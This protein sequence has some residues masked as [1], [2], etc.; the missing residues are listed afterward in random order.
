[1]IRSGYIFFLILLYGEFASHAANRDSL[2]NAWQNKELHDTLRRDAI[3]D[4]GWSYVN[5]NPDS[6][7]YY[8]KLEYNFCVRKKF[9]VGQSDAMNTTGV[10]YLM[11]AEYDSALVYLER[12]AQLLE[13][14]G[15]KGKA[16]I[17]K[18][19]I[20]SIYG[21]QDKLM[22]ALD[23]FYQAAEIFE[24]IEDSVLLVKAFFNIGVV[25]KKM[26]ETDVAL[27]HYFRALETCKKYNIPDME[28][29][30]YANIANTYKELGKID[31]SGYYIQKALAIQVT[32]G[33]IEG[34]GRSHNI[35]ADNFLL[36]GL[37]DSAKVHAYTA[38]SI[39]Q[40]ID[41]IQGI[42]STSNLLGRIHFELARYDS[43]L[44][45][46]NE[47]LR[48][49]IQ[50]SS[51][52]EQSSA[53]EGLARV[54]EK[55]GSY[56]D[57]LK[58]YKLFIACSDS[59]NSDENFKALAQQEMQ[60]E[61]NKKALH[62]S[63]NRRNELTAVQL[64]GEKQQAVA[65]EAGRRNLVI[66]SGVL[67]ALIL[68]GVIAVILYRSNKRRK[69][70]HEIISHQKSEV[71]LQKH[72]LEEKNDEITDSI[73]YAKRIQSAILPPVKLV[74]S[75]LP[76]SFVLYQ[77]KDIVAGDFYWCHQ[78]GDTLLLGVSDCTGHGVPGALVSVVCNNALT[79]SVSEYK[80]TVPNLVLDK[81]RELV[82]ETFERSE[83]QVRDGMDMALIAISKNAAGVYTKL[84]F[85]GANNGLYIIRN[86][87]LTE[88]KPDK[89]P[90]GKF[91][92]ARPFTLQTETLEPGDLVFLFSDGFADQFGGPKAK[93]LKY[94][95]LKDF[96]CNYHTVKMSGMEA[97]LQRFFND[98]RGGYEQIDDVCIIGFRVT[99]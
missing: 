71:E 96:L 16:G 7:V 39:R 22:N 1:M 53:Y 46:F 97:K 25:H 57:A 6:A 28:S 80:L 24:E 41:D 63:L 9:P 45:Y 47:G 81:T 18:I 83:D 61:F 42:A 64:A 50:S 98:W 95:P 66:L 29:L 59:L 65:K 90:V 43:A 75:Y 74:Q 44:Y 49:G 99:A 72:L 40:R 88:L 23:Y 55:K 51:L 35:I 8:S 4:L 13:Q 67:A 17:A 31:S 33:D 20:G 10:A 76:D 78:A 15:E 37:P 52:I 73:I 12:S 60:Y 30:S 92:N 77:P 5:S 85:A 70:D 34:Q 84:Q 89:Q 32:L 56:A 3:H 82:L 21:R 62:D 2:W 19:N 26:G 27:K 11:K 94:Q 36:L 14:I 54:Y 68:A 91:E 79:R 48:A 87:I 69:K 38:I 58:N 93:K 86:G